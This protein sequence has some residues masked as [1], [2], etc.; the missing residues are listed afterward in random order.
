MEISTEKIQLAELQICTVCILPQTFP[1]IT[2]NAEG[3]CNFCQKSA[4]RESTLDQDKKLYEQKFLALLAN[5][6][7]GTRC[8]PQNAE[9]KSYDILMAYSGGKDSTYTMSLLKLKYGLRILAVSFDNGFISDTATANIK[10]IT[11][12]LGIDHIFFKPKWEILKKVFGAARERELYSKKSLERASTICT[13]CMTLVKS[14]CMKMSI[15]QDIP[16]IGYGWSPGQA[17][18]QAAI[19]KNNAA[20]FRMTQQAV[21]QPLKEVAGDE[22]EVYFLQEK[23]YSNSDKFPYNVHPMAWEFYDE[24]KIREEIKQYGWKAPDD[25]DSN[26]TNCLL[27]AYANDIHLTKYRY[28]PYV[29]EIANMVRDGI[30]AR[31]EGYTKIYSKS[32]SALVRFARQKL[33]C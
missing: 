6:G 8:S 31:D 20:F 10:K 33:E 9:R 19:M 26:S 32:P 23:H 4:S 11:D 15:E 21:L 5:L 7:I 1:G 30:M 22:I 2:F 17:S 14:T 28:H 25:T 27:N 3:V 13:S 12:S 18:L 24:A 16:L 29:W